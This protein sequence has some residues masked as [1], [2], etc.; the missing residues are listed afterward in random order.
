MVADGGTNQKYGYSARALMALNKHFAGAP[1][2]RQ[3]SLQDILGFSITASTVFDQC[4]YLGNDLQPIFYAFLALAANAQHF[5]LDD[6]THRILDQ[7]EIQ[8]KNATA[9]S[10][11]LVYLVINNVTYEFS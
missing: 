8:K 6:T 5:H 3:E 7:K 11:K 10:Y 4:E 9:I 2:Y 1:F